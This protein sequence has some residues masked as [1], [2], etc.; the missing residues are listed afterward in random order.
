MNTKSVLTALIGAASAL[1]IWATGAGAATITYTI[2]GTGSGSTELGTPFGTF[3]TPFT[4]VPFTIQILGDSTYSG[5][6]SVPGHYVYAPTATLFGFGG[7]FPLSVDLPYTPL[8][9]DGV[10]PTPVPGYGFTVFGYND[11]PWSPGVF[12][13]TTGFVGQGLDT[14]DLLGD[15]AP[16]PVLFYALPSLDVINGPEIDFTSITGATFSVDGIAETGGVPEPATWAVMLLGF[17]GV[18]AGLRARRRQIA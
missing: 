9:T 18:G 13:V 12:D 17:G 4:D 14:Y 3:V 15:L 5:P 16:I 8:I 1:S 2:T 10:L 6:D 7:T 11:A